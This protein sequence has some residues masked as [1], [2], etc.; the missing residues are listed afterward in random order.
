MRLPQPTVEV[1]QQDVPSR[2]KTVQTKPCRVEQTEEKYAGA[3]HRPKRT[4]VV[5]KARERKTKQDVTSAKR[6][7]NVPRQHDAKQVSQEHG[8][9]CDRERQR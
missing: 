3:E 5:G 4:I 9:R 8:E 2:A 6:S 1:E 7:T